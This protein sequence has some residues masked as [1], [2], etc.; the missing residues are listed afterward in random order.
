MRPLAIALTLLLT[1]MLAA[2][3]LRPA[4]ADAD[5]PINAVYFSGP[6][7]VID[8]AELRAAGVRL[9]TTFAAFQS[10]ATTADAII[11][12][13]ETLPSVDR[14]WL[15]EQLRQSKLIVGLNIPIVEVAAYTRFERYSPGLGNFL[16]DYGG[17]PF[18]SYV[19]QR[20]ELSSVKRTGAG[21]DRIYS[22]KGFLGLLRFMT[23]QVTTDYTPT[24]SP[25]DPPL[26]PRPRP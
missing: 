9:V 15:A 16:Q 19:L 7:P 23:E 10:A 13:R 3:A 11:L 5:D 24:R 4:R 25:S 2:L 6:T 26:R 17:Q 18:Y 12:D 14:D 21:S 1:A 22:A 8:R 20:T